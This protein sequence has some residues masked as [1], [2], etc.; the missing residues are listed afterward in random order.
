L[1][2]QRPPSVSEISRCLEFRS[3]DTL[4]FREPNLCRQIAARRRDSGIAVSS[5]KPIF[6]RSEGYRLE[7]MLRDHLAQESPLSVNEIASKL[8]YKAAQALRERF[9]ELCR[10]ITAKRKQQPLRGKEKLRLALEAARTAS[11][12]PSL[13]QI[14]RRLGFSSE[15]VLLTTVREYYGGPPS[16]FRWTVNIVRY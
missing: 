7:N 8:G 9:P 14:A 11:P 5:T 3:D 13:M 10:A 1:S 16:A 4:R 6:K 12:P 15:E 2:E